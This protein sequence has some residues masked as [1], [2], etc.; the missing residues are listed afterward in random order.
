MKSQPFRNTH[1]NSRFVVFSKKAQSKRHQHK[2]TQ[3]LPGT[4]S[5]L[6]S[7][8]KKHYVRRK[9]TKH[10]LYTSFEPN[11][12]PTISNYQNFGPKSH[13]SNPQL[14]PVDHLIEECGQIQVRPNPSI[15]LRQTV[16]QPTMRG[17]YIYFF[18]LRIIK[19]IL[20]AVHTTSAKLQL[21]SPDSMV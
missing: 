16:I 10:P 4:L 1:G 7:Y 2:N 9:H 3:P 14:K 21:T 12:L 15:P 11:V 20:S 8:T 13:I 19:Y 17:V 5:S 6:H 18:F